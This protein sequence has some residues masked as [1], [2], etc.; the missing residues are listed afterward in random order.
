MS[1]NQDETA[2]LG[3]SSY[4]HRSYTG[5]AGCPHACRLW[6][7]REVEFWWFLLSTV[8]KIKRCL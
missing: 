8:L 6:P 4:L 3:F 1:P 5:E 7:N 2:V